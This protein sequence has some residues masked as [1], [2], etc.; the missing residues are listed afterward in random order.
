M[1]SR[2]IARSVGARLSPR[3][4]ALVFTAIG[5]AEVWTSRSTTGLG[6]GAQV[7]FA[8]FT[9]LTTLT[10]LGLG[11]WPMGVALVVPA[12][13]ALTIRTI[14]DFS[15]ISS[16]VAILAALYA[17]GT[18]LTRRRTSVVLLCAVVSAAF[19]SADAGDLAF[20][21]ML[22]V[23]AGAAGMLVRR[24]RRLVQELASSNR[25]LKEER[26]HSAQLAV[27][28]ERTRISREVHDILAHTLSVVVIQA[29]MA[30]ELLDREPSRSRAAL[31]SIQATGREALGDMRRLIGFLRESGDESSL[32]PQPGL[33]SVPELV[34]SMTRAGVAVTLHVDGPERELTAGLDLCAYRIVQEALTNT[35]K[36]A[37]PVAA[38]V[39]IRYRRSALN[40]EIDD[41]GRVGAGRMARGGT[42]H[43]LVGM[44]ERVALY[45]GELHVGPRPQGGYSVK[46]RLPYS[47]GAS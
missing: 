44:R 4:A 41:Q 1:D 6:M 40:I 5:Q 15:P 30:E 12:L 24:E 19:S 46:A 23:A 21:A 11:R 42:G 27:A 9:G 8:A 37:G 34:D 31:V 18:A 36:H 16:V 17:A 26:E 33:S 29:E 25:A 43:G 7:L 28:H 39:V 3:A 35:L 2:R 13:D 38:D 45:G 20:A 14:T 22:Y 47:W 10:L 32:A